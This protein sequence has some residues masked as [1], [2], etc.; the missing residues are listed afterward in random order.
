MPLNNKA[1]IPDVTV[2]D[3]GRDQNRDPS[4]H[5]SARSSDINDTRLVSRLNVEEFSL[6]HCNTATCENIRFGLCRG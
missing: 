2:A 6:F 3:S 1:N 4:N 5:P